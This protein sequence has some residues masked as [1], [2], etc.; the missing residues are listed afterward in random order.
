M[1][2]P[3]FTAPQFIGKEGASMV[4]GDGRNIILVT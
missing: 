2:A 4:L 1:I 3:T